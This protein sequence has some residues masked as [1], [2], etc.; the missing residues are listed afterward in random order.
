MIPPTAVCQ[1]SVVAKFEGQLVVNTFDYVS[2]TPSPA[3]GVPDVS[4]GELLLA[5][6]SVW[7]SSILPLFP[8]QYQVGLYKGMV[9]EARFPASVPGTPVHPCEPVYGDAE[10]IAGV[11]TTDAGTLTGD[12]LPSYCAVGCQKL[13]ARVGRNWR[14]FTHFTPVSEAQ[15]DLGVLTGGTVT[16]YESALVNFLQFTW[17]TAPLQ[18]VMKLCVFSRTLFLTEGLTAATQT[19]NQSS[20]M[21]HVSGYRVQPNLGSQLTRKKK[22]AV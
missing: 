7:R 4:V 15:Q 18:M 2:S 19:P 5:F 8:F 20:F 22:N 16:A 6:R 17:G 14:G 21:T 11:I 10:S 12:V 3:V 13:N 9:T 1:V